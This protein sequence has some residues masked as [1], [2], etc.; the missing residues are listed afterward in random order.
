VSTLVLIWVE[1]RQIAHA[2]SLREYFDD[3]WNIVDASGL[4]MY[5]IYFVDKVY[6][7]GGFKDDASLVLTI[8]IIFGVLRGFLSG[9]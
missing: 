1:C 9:L 4:A 7:S 2:K 8:S 3:F 5:L 6:F